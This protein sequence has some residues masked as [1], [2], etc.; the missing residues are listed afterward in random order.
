MPRRRKV[1]LKLLTEKDGEYYRRHSAC[2]YRL[3]WRDPVTK[4]SRR[5]FVSDETFA[6]KLQLSIED[7]INIGNLDLIPRTIQFRNAM[8]RFLELDMADATHDEYKRT[9]E[10][11]GELTGWPNSDRWNVNII[12][13]FKQKRK[14]QNVED[15]TIN[16]DLRGLTRF[17]NFCKSRYGIENPFDRLM[18]G[19]R[20]IKVIKKVPVIWTPQ[21]FESILTKFKNDQQWRIIA[22][23][24]LTGVGRRNSLINL[25]RAN[26]NLKNETISIFEPKP[27]KKNFIRYILG[28]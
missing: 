9:L 21:Q 13:Y 11:F 27:K 2:P 18:R 5:R 22:L 8:D 6:R 15:T 16:K 12:A 23:M 28:L 24:S 1:N 4:K 26:I 17:F 19:E 20:R 14:A 7:K 3:E 25:K 10:R